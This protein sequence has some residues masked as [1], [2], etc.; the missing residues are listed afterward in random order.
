MTFLFCFVFGEFLSYPSSDAVNMPFKIA[1][2]DQ[3]GEDVLHEGWN[4]AGVEAKLFFVNVN[5]MLGKH[6]I[7]NAQRWRDRF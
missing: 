6:H 2:V 4:G 7:S 5:Q 1:V 3:L